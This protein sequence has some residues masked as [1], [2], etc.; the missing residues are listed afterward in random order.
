MR[1]KVLYNISRFYS[2]S[3]SS[4]ERLRVWDIFASV[5]LVRPPIT[6]PPMNDIE[7]R[8]HDFMLEKELEDSLL[9]DFE[10]RQLRDE[11]YFFVTF[12]YFPSCLY[13]LFSKLSEVTVSLHVFFFKILL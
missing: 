11:R 9:C 1:Y 6:A 12:F 7:K 3:A 5:A 13:V 10:L 8:H 4:S 2:S